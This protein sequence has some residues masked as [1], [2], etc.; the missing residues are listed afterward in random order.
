MH[1]FHMYKK[2]GELRKARD[3]SE[4]INYELLPRLSLRLLPRR[5]Q[6]FVV[7]PLTK[8]ASLSAG[9]VLQDGGSAYEAIK[10]LE[11]GRT[12]IANLTIV[13]HRDA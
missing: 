1:L 11:A 9:A 7:Q 13:S 8:I 6:Q 2:V 10:L 5:D 4:F 12:M 3:L